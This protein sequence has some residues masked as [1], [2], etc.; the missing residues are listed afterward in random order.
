[1]L[2]LIGPHDKSFAGIDT[3][4][5]KVHDIDVQGEVTFRDLIEVHDINVA[6]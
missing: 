6:S 2:I 1:M 5:F 3:V 4:I